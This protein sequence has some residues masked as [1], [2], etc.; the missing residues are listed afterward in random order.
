MQLFSFIAIVLL[1]FV[2]PAYAQFLTGYDQQQ[3]K[4]SVIKSDKALQGVEL[5]IHTPKVAPSGMR[6]A[7]LNPTSRVVNDAAVNEYEPFMTRSESLK[8]SDGSKSPVDISADQMTRDEGADMVSASGD[9]FVSQ[10][11]RILRA[12]D[13][14]YNVGADR[15]EAQGDVVLN[16]ANGDIH[17]VDRAEYYNSLRN[18]DV[19]NLRTTLNDGSRFK[20]ESGKMREG[21][22]TTM[23]GANYTPCPECKSDPDRAPAWSISAAKVTHFQEESRVSYKHA[24][25]NAYG[26]PI[27]Y[28]PYF[29]HPDGTINQKSGVLA[30]SGGYK[31]DLGVF[32]DGSYYWGIS[33]SQDATLGVVAYSSQA[34]LGYAQ[35][36][37]RWRDAYLELAGSGT[38]SERDDRI[39]DQ[40]VTVGEE[41]RGHIEANGLWNM[42]EKWRSGL[43][44]NWASDDQY[45]S[46]YDFSDEEVLESEL[47]AERFSGRNYASGR[48]LSFQDNRLRDTPLDQPDVLPEITASFIGEPGAVPIIKGQWSLGGSA[49]ALNRDGSDQDVQRFS[50]DAGWE[51]RLVSDYGLLTN[52]NAHVRTD[53]YHTDDRSVAT[54]GSGRSSSSTATRVFPQLHVQSSYP[55]ARPFE[56]MQAR[57]EPLVALTLAPKV[58]DQDDIPNEDSNDVQIDASNLFERNRFPGLDRVE[59]QSRLTYGFRTGLFGYD[60]SHGDVFLG[61]SYRFDNNNNP[62]PNGSGLENQQSDFVGR[63]SGQYKDVYDLSYRFQIGSEELSSQRHELQASADWNRF[64]V[65]A[66][67]LFAAPVA[68]TGTLESREQ[69]GVN[70]QFYLTPEWRTRFGGI[71]DLGEDP[72]LR[73]AYA[74]IDYLGQ[75]VFWSLTGER[76][77]TSAA[78]GDSSTEVVFRVGLKNLGGFERT[79][80]ERQNP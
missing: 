58:L 12:D 57:I 50:F 78:S 46:Q 27:M 60:G 55:M 76:N 65:Q 75:C 1:T 49:L 24:R 64:L 79:G 10:D 35:Y 2:T 33:P 38:S 29:S 30:P 74:G 45:M 39:G 44:I 25:F 47:Y 63:V 54:A 69:L 52:V 37:K 40:T 11:G 43:H 56:N 6:F 32:V 31:S 68:D 9:V 5:Y 77:L 15:I 28:L 73:E 19:D 70:T 7:S 21:E 20:A 8:A 34:P 61:Q 26:V 80:Y 41:A 72:G 66:S 59:D 42:N 18:G 67:Y 22:T 51:R 14:V 3:P 36:R 62:F 71:Q 16:E 17:L 53:A 13:I 4:Q 23:R 48:I